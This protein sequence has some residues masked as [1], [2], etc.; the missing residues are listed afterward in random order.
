MINQGNLDKI[1][2]LKKSKEKTNTSSSSFTIVDNRIYYFEKMIEEL[3]S[4]REEL[5]QQQTKPVMT[6]LN[7]RER[8]IKPNP[9][10]F[11]IKNHQELFHLGQQFENDIVAGKKLF[12]LLPT[13]NK[14]LQ[15]L[16]VLGLASY[17]NYQHQRRVL[18]LT[19][20][21]A[22][23]VYKRIDD[24]GEDIVVSEN[25]SSSAVLTS[26]SD[27]IA[28][29]DLDSLNLY[30]IEKAQATLN[31]LIKFYDVVLFDVRS[32]QLIPAQ[33]SYYFYLFT[34]IDNLSMVIHKNE[35][36]FTQLTK[37]IDTAKSYNIELKGMIWCDFSLID[38]HEVINEKE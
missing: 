22:N 8:V 11:Q 12:A 3:N 9:F 32:I 10:F 26:E 38:G 25:T 14:K 36:K 13:G 23:T 4:L 6:D 5:Q 16:T 28:L 1:Y 18:I 34:L 7:L 29:F 30:S 24:L 20:G 15:E 19:H 21:V 37:L 35:T 33:A 17:L 27:G 31:T 2:Y